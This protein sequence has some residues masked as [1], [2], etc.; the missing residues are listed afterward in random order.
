M[1]LNNLE[2]CS[3]R[4]AYVLRHSEDITR[5]YGGWVKISDIIQLTK[6]TYE[7]ISEVVS[8]DKKGRFEIDCESGLIRATYGHSVKV[9]MDYKEAVPPE[10]LLHGTSQHF[11]D[12]ILNDGINPRGRQ[13]VHL[14][15]DLD[16]AID[17]GGRHGEVS[18]LNVDALRMHGQGFKF[19][20]PVPH[21]WLVSSVPAQ[22]IKYFRD[23][24]MEE[25]NDFIVS[26]KLM[27]V[28]ALDPRSFDT[29]ECEKMTE[30]CDF[31]HISEYEATNEYRLTIL[32]ANYDDYQSYKEEIANIRQNSADF[33][34]FDTSL[35]DNL[36]LDIPCVRTTEHP[37]IILKSLYD[38]LFSG[39]PLP[40]NYNDFRTFLFSDEKNV[41]FSRYQD[42]TNKPNNF[43]DYIRNVISYHHPTKILLHFAIPKFIDDMREV[44]NCINK[45]IRMIPNNVEFVWGCSY[46][47]ESSLSVAVFYK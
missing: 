21:I 11:V 41:G 24:T 39:Y 32:F 1:N 38:I 44:S 19:Y 26:Q 20:N 34:L 8:K 29:H 28:V 16:V 2:Q 4:L 33:I 31:C 35:D 46:T 17:T 18:V 37:H 47:D 30:L 3:K 9:E 22:Y 5:I 13:Y 36:N 7:T 6:L 43:H 23:N 27:C 40:I 15:D 10:I 12:N 45:S 42:Y 25:I 14:T